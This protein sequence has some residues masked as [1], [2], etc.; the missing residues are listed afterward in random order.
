MERKTKAGVI[1]TKKKK[2]IGLTK[3]IKKMN[4]QKTRMKKQKIR[5]LIKKKRTKM[6]LLGTKAVRKIR[7]NVQLSLPCGI[8]TNAIQRSVQECS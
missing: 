4:S 5:R 2:C 8:S 3:Q 7:L 1:K 6:S